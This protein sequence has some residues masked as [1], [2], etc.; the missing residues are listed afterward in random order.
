MKI[1]DGVPNFGTRLAGAEP[2]ASF[3]DPFFTPLQMAYALI[4][5][6]V[7]RFKTTCGADFVRRAAASGALGEL[8][9]AIA[10][11]ST[12]MSMK[13]HMYGGERPGRA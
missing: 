13:F 5:V 7:S 4:V 1:F 12:E 10:A 6:S 3:G 8:E 9:M 11:G 2:M